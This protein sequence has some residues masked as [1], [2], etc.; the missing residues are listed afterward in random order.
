MCVVMGSDKVGGDP[1][2]D[3]AQSCQPQCADSRMSDEGLAS[4]PTSAT[5]PILRTSNV[6]S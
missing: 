4:R 6:S 2:I 1:G 5:T 3:E